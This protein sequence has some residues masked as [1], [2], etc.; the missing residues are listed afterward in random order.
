MTSRDKV[1]LYFVVA[2]I[3]LL[4]GLTTRL[5]H[6]LKDPNDVTQQG[7]DLGGTFELI[8]TKGNLVTDE[9]LLGAYTL[10][11][12]GYTYCPDVCP[13]S[14]Q[15][16]SLALDMIP[17][18]KANKVVSVL[19][20]VDPERDTPEVLAEYVKHFHHSL[21]GLSG[22]P[23]Q[24]KKAAQAYRVYYQKVVEDGKPAEDYLM[25]HSAFLYLMGPDGNNI[26]FFNH[27]I[28]PEELA[29]GLDEHIS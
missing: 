10:V 27:G 17:T 14:L 1:L 4:V 3:F 26:T 9:D 25:D 16:A 28:S 29:K 8:D 12:F 2:A 20:T 21:V 5:P 19:I 13:T 7:V 18:R 15:T 6:M 24:I 23:E 22:S 11:Y